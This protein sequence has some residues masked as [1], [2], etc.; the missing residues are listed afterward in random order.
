MQ[1]L[2]KQNSEH[3]CGVPAGT[4]TLIT[5]YFRL[6]FQ[7]GSDSVNITVLLYA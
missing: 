2:D 5:E 7:D 3:D 6:F 1:K 4:M